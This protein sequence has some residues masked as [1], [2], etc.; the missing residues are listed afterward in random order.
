MKTMWPS[1]LSAG[2]VVLQHVARRDEALAADGRCRRAP[3]GRAR[4]C[5]TSNVADS[6]GADRRCARRTISSLLRPTSAPGRSRRP[7]PP[8]APR[9]TA[10]GRGPRRAGPASRNSIGTRRIDRALDI[11]VDAAVALGRGLEQRR[12]VFTVPAC[13]GMNA[14]SARHWPAIVS[15]LLRAM[16][17][18]RRGGCEPPLRSK[19]KPSDDRARASW[20]RPGPRRCPGI[21][22]ASFCTSRGSVVRRQVAHHAADRR[23][24]GLGEHH[25]EGDHRGAL[26]GELVDQASRRWCAA[27]AIGRTRPAPPRRYRRCGPACRGWQ[28]A[29]LD[30]AGRC[31]RRG[32]AGGSIP[33]GSS[34]AQQQRVQ[35]H[36]AWPR[37]TA[38]AHCLRPNN[39]P[40]RIRRSSLLRTSLYGRT[41]TKPNSAPC[42]PCPPTAPR[43][44]ARHL[45][46]AR[47]ARAVLHH[48]CHGEGAG[49]VYGPFQLMLFRSAIAMRADR[50]H[51]LA[52][53]RP[54]VCAATGPGCRRC[55]SSPASAARLGFFYVFPRMPLVDAYA[56]SFAAPLFM[57][58]L[59]VPMLGEQVGWRRWTRRRGGLRRRDRHARSA[60]H[61]VPLPC[62]WSCWARPSATRCRP[63]WC[64]LVSRHDP[65][66][67]H[68]LL[69]LPSFASAVV[70]GRRHPGL[71]LAD[72]RSTGSG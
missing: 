27:T 64:A 30:A 28:V 71:D 61:L 63:C 3:C 9:S 58:A 68:A 22:A 42:R 14:R 40:M 26:L 4:R 39:Q 38:R 16:P 52:R 51:R 46:Q 1:S 53:G 11:G 6:D 36:Q 31:R 37:S 41:S 21:A 62:R 5:S 70:A 69:V 48:G 7:G 56:I 35:Q 13:C 25:V 15:P 59:A 44:P 24:V 49:R 29:G 67:R 57:V 34:G 23:A 45:L 19:P 8:A 12:C 18:K 65:R 66:R 50:R 43:F 72:A 54:R 10:P 17:A 47:L 2:T 60:G 32:R 55:A 20:R 33:A